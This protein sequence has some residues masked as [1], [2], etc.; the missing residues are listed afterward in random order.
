[1]A[2]LE[3]SEHLVDGVVEPHREDLPAAVGEQHL[4]RVRVR[5]SS[6]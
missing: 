5:V 2:V 1:V 4:V 6:Q 3:V